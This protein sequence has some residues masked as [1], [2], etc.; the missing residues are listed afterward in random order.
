MS[1]SVW[2]PLLGQE[3]SHREQ[4]PRGGVSWRE[5]FPGEEFQTPQ[6]A[7]YQTASSE[8]QT[9]N[10]APWLKNEAEELVRCLK[11]A[12]PKLMAF[13]A[14]DLCGGS[15]ELTSESRPLAF[16]CILRHACR[17]T[18]ALSHLIDELIWRR[19]LRQDFS[20]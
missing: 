20:M 7:E 3:C 15:R 16:M 5:P 10:K 19:R 1:L 6:W 2:S 9:L 13:D 14:R 17:K 12:S 11:G 8:S 4:P 18:Q